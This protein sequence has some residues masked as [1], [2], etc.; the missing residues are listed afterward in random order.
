MVKTFPARG[1]TLIELLVA[2]SL[3][4]IIGSFGL[5]YYSS[6]NR[7][8]VVEQATKKIVSDIRLAQNLA[9]SQQKP[10]SI[11]CTCTAL[12]SYSFVVDVVGSSYWIIPDCEPACVDDDNKVKEVGLENVTLSGG[13][14]W[15]KFSVLSQGVGITP[16]GGQLIIQSKDGLYRRE[17]VVGDG[18]SLTIEE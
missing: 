1:F 10:N 11:D 18:G 14:E 12:K 16:A 9:L 6:F 17:I 5:A 2:I 13:L 8:Q 4:V 7:R 3:A 15:I